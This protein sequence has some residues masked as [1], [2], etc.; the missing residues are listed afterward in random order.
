MLVDDGCMQGENGCMQV[1]DLQNAVVDY[2]KQN[3][4]EQEEELEAEEPEVK[5]GVKKNLGYYKKKKEID[6]VKGDEKYWADCM[7]DNED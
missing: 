5:K 1:D 3:E 7:Y 4:S 6:K 2:G